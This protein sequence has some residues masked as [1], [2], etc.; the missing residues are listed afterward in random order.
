MDCKP[1]CSRGVRRLSLSIAGLAAA[2]LCPM[3]GQAAV[4]IMIQPV[5][6]FAGSSGNTFDILLQNTGSSTVN[7]GSFTFEIN[8]PDADINLS[9]ATTATVPPY[10]F[11][12]HSLFGPTINTTSG[13]TLD[14]SD[15]YDVPFS[16]AALG[17]GVTVGLGRITLDVS[18]TAALGSFPVS[19]VPSATSLSDPAGDTIPIDLFIGGQ[20]TIDA[21]PVPEPGSA[22]LMAGALCLVL[23]SV[24]PAR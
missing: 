7:V 14:A 16:G 1:K 13:Q 23:R 11:S 6:A 5:S 22:L 12:G 10:V 2:L 20:I 4:I 9:S 17:S 19:L 8:T 24:R 3:P 15:S 21:N 18:T